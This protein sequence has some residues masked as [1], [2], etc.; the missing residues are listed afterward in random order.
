MKD[1][2]ELRGRIAA[3]PATEQLR[4]LLMVSRLER[5]AIPGKRDSPEPAADQLLKSD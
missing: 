2:D 4:L 3:L 5:A 1:Y